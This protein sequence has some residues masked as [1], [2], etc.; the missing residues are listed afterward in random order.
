MAKKQLRTDRLVAQVT[1]EE[2][3]KFLELAD[4]EHLQVSDLIRRLLHQAADSKQ[5]TA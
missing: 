5:V 1:S 4:R 2:K 3:R